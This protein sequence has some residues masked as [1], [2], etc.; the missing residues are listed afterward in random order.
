MGAIPAARLY[1][2]KYRELAPLQCL[3]HIVLFIFLFMAYERSVYGIYHFQEPIILWHIG[4]KT[5]LF[6]AYRAIYFSVHN[7][8]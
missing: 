1:H 2:T 8:P 5:S 3:W 4:K 6:M 7:I